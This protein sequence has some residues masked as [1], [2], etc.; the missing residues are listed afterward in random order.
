MNWI[1]PEER[2]PTEE[3]KQYLCCCRYLGR[4]SLLIAYFALN[5]ADNKMSFFPAEEYTRPGFYYS[6]SEYGD[7]E[8]NN[9]AYWTEIDLPEGA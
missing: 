7:I 1:K 4:S 8:I 9:V 3:H 2:L 6:D 5:L